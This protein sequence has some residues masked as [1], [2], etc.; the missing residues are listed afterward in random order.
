MAFSAD[1]I[2]EMLSMDFRSARVGGLVRDGREGAEEAGRRRWGTAE[3]LNLGRARVDP[4]VNC[5]TESGT[6]T[7]IETFPTFDASNDNFIIV[8]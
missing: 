4:P 7:E 2:V 3:L 1:L 8:F 6:G 5:I